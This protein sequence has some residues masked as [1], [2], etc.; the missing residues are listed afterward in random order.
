M[1]RT[2][3]D[4][5]GS[6]N[7][8]KAPNFA[9]FWSSFPF[10]PSQLFMSRAVASFFFGGI[11]EANKPTQDCRSETWRTWTTQAQGSGTPLSSPSLAQGPVGFVGLV[12]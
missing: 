10:L 12:Q 4:A 5:R 3:G 7:F 11:L 9:Y 8:Q 2:E 1:S 6:R